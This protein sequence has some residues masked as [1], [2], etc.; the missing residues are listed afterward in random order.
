MAFN[1][2]ES[3]WKYAQKEIKNVMKNEVVDVIKDVEQKVIQ[4]VVLDAYEPTAYD[5][6]SEMGN[7]EEGLISKDN[8]VADYEEGSNFIQINVTNDTKGNTAYSYSTSGYIDEI[9]EFGEGYTWKQ[10]EIYK[11]KLPR[12]FTATTQ[13]EIDNSDIIENTIKKNVNFE[14]K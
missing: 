12:P 14:I 3:L 7:G 9:V 4:R 10:S 13:E 1:D 5:R 6:R 2:L 8:M 11:T